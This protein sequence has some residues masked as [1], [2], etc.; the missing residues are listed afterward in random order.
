MEI[1]AGETVMKIAYDTRKPYY[2]P[3]L[4]MSNSQTAPYLVTQGIQ[5]AVSIPIVGEDVCLGILNLGSQKEMGFSAEQIAFLGTIAN[6]LGTALRNAHLY[7]KLEQSYAELKKT[8]QQLIQSEKLRAMGELSV[9]VAHD[10]NNLLMAILGHTQLLLAQATDPPLRK[11]LLVIEEAALEGAST[12][13]R[14]QDFTRQ[15]A[16][17]PFEPVNVVELLEETLTLTRSRWKDSAYLEGIQFTIRANFS[18]VPWVAGN[19]SELREVFANILINALEA[20]PAGGSLSI[21]AESR[22]SQ[23]VIAFTDSGVGMGEEVR[24]RVFDPFFTTKPGEGKGLGMSVAYSIISRHQGAIEI[25]SAPGAG[26]TVRVVLPAGAGRVEKAETGGGEV[27]QSPP[28]PSLGFLVIDDEAP[29]RDFL[30]ELLSGQGHSVLVAADGA[31]GME[32]FHQHRPEIVITDLGMPGMSGW[33]VAAA[34]KVLEPSARVLLMT[35]WGNQ[36]DPEKARKSGI[37]RVLAKPFQIADI[38][39]LLQEMIGSLPARP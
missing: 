10:F 21:G 1:P 12:I 31:A 33:E 28:P 7:S 20:M 16:D 32:L 29:I 39:Q 6:S 24:S 2:T 14:L 30:E 17:Q 9:G 34:I 8:Q 11:G 5:S 27:A 26:T 3:L 23:V 22:E 13:R 37:D 36:L 18:E 38:Q 15:R 4:D 19:S 25:E 35:G